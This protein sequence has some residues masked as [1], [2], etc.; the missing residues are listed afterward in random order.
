MPLKIAMIPIA[1]TE[2]IVALLPSIDF[3]AVMETELI[4]GPAIRKTSAA[5]GENPFRTNATAIGTD[6]LEQT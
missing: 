6:A 5:P 1:A 2:I 4:P 3:I